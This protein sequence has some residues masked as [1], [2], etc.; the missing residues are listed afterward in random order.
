MTG[1]AD[2]EASLRGIGNGPD[3]GFDIAG[4]ALAL[5]ALETPGAELTSYRSHLD[6]LARDVGGAATANQASSVRACAACLAQVVFGQ[7]GY[8]GDDLTYDDLQNANFMRVIDRR[9]GLPVALGIVYL[10]AARA[11]GWTAYG[12]NFPGH[13]LIALEASGERAILD[14]F[15]EG[16]S[17]TSPEL[18]ELLKAVAGQ[19][20]EL[21][22]S[23]YAPVADRA[24]LLRL[25]SNVKLRLLQ[26]QD[27]ERA[28]AIVES[29]LLIAP[30]LGLLWYEAGMLHGRL[31]N[32]VA[33]T[34]A[35]ESCLGVEKDA[36][37]RQEA[38]ALLQELRRRMN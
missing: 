33:A 35:L 5:A 29:M 13:F 30:G 19:D 36:A 37:R 14:P 4:G 27:V 9:K 18:R 21:D 38:T 7:Y 23:M 25:Q 28:V 31:G 26:M 20:A 22:T 15:H 2:I 34:R 8:R 16:R 1:R 12:L 32:I 6:G 10:H 3:H 17:R 11:Q 24:V